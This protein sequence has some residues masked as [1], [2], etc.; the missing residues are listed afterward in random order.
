MEQQSGVG[1]L[2][3]GQVLADASCFLCFC[4][5]S[6]QPATPVSSD[7]PFDGVA[8]AILT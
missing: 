8:K 2:T 3:R 4:G 1:V 7:F 5:F 6:D